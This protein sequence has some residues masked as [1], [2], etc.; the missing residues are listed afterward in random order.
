MKETHSLLKFL[1]IFIFILNLTIKCNLADSIC[2]SASACSRCKYIDVNHDKNLFAATC[3]RFNLTSVPVI[4]PQKQLGRLYIA[5]NNISEIS[6]QL[7]KDYTYL[8]ILSLNAN[9]L[10]VITNGSF[11]H[12]KFLEKLYISGNRIERL[13]KNKVCF[14]LHV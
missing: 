9:S 4:I 12:N 3:N 8:K 10:T 13:H 11:K 1:A 6:P 7:M 2:T 14:T 5:F